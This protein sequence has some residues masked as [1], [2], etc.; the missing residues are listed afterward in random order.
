MSNIATHPPLSW[1]KKIV[2]SLITTGGLLALCELLLT[3][4]G[5]RPITDIQDPFVGFSQQIPLMQVIRDNEGIEH[6]HTAENKLVWFNAQYFPKRKAAGTK[7]VFCLGGSTTYGHPYDDNTS[8]CGWLRELLPVADNSHTWEVINCGGISYASYRVAAVME[9]L[10]QYEPDLFIV[11]SVHNEFLERRTY[12]GMFEKSA[13]GLRIHSTL[14]QTRTYAAVDRVVQALRDKLQ[15][16]VAQ[17]TRKTKKDILPGEV[18]EILNH[19]V[20]PRDYH[21]D[22]DWRS[23]VI[24]HYELN[25]TRMVDIARRS[26]ASVVFVTPASNER[27]CAPFKSE[28]NA[29]MDV[30]NQDQF[31]TLMHRAEEQANVGNFEA[32]LNT[33]KELEVLAPDFAHV[34][35]RIGQLLVELKRWDEAQIAFKRAINE[36]V[37]PLRAVDEISQAIRRVGLANKVPIVDF[38]QRLHDKCEQDFGHRCLGEEYFSDHVHPTIEVNQQLALWII[39]ELQQSGWIDGRDLGKLESAEELQAASKRVYDRID[40]AAHGIALRNLAKVLHWAG[41]FEESAPRA[42]DAMVLLPDDPESRFVLADSLRHM[43]DN[44]GALQ[45]YELL[46]SG[47]ND[48]GRA[49]FPYAELLVELN[50]FAKAKPYL[51]LGILRDPTSAYGR[52]LLGKVH[53]ELGEF[54]FAVESLTE[55]DRLFP[56][57][58]ATLKLLEEAKS[59]LVE[60]P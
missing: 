39:E 40:L 11:Y 16:D 10:S 9:E 33:L 13:L 60:L 18:D 37:C 57:D 29:E 59:R 53:L 26:G 6:V 49:Y 3:A 28:L 4:S 47:T 1:R 14:S 32:S 20:G 19:T 7:R 2:F 50:E 38:E 41:R 21:R 17:T 31:W 24:Q 15:G 45:Q 25:L 34:H 36:D 46:F 35:Y 12:A 48:W 54:T 8:F 30:D 55:A 5:I 52:Y 42:M 58:T 44:K 23:K 56:N 51:L 43:G 27:H 22:L